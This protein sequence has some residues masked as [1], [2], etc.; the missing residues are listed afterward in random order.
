MFCDG[1]DGS[2][3]RGRMDT[4]VCMAESLHYHH[5]VNS[6]IPI[7][8]KRLKRD[9]ETLSSWLPRG[10]WREH[11]PGHE[12]RTASVGVPEEERV[13]G[14]RGSRNWSSVPRKK[15]YQEQGPVRSR[16]A[17]QERSQEIPLP[18]NLSL[19]ER[20]VGRH[21]QTQAARRESW[22]SAPG[23]SFQAAPGVRQAASKHPFSRLSHTEGRESE[24]VGGWG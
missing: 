16:A 24:A 1:L 17:W 15:H 20:R 14:R 7:Q 10:I 18:G 9:K 4:R 8:N 3:V 11:R 19:V 13:L 2:R 21:P 5:L 23:W 6:Y 22:L 12:A